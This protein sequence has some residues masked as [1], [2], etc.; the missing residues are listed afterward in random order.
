MGMQRVSLSIIAALCLLPSCTPQ[1]QGQTSAS[2]YEVTLDEVKG[3]KIKFT[4]APDYPDAAFSYIV[5][6]EEEGRGHSVREL[7]NIQIAELR[8]LYDTWAAE[9]PSHEGRFQDMFCYSGKRS[10]KSRYLTDDTDYKLIVYQ[11]NPF[12]YDVLGDIFSVNFHTPKVEITEMDF[13]V[14]IDGDKLSIIPSDN[15]ITYYWDYEL[16]SKVY[17][18]FLNPYFYFYS[19]LDLYEDYD[20]M[21]HLLSK[22]PDEWVFS[23][24]DVAIKEGAEYVLCIA[25]YMNGEICSDVLEMEFTYNK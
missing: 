8:V 14:V 18:D 13:D 15:N 17:D 2:P 10:I 5:I 23:R 22:G 24:D 11:L 9:N 7:V 21:D 25:T 19:L 12:T 3:T 4:M 20:F 1:N 6:P 16:K